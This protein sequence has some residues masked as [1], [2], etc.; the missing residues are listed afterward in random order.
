MALI[1]RVDTTMYALGGTRQF[2]VAVA[3]VAGCQSRPTPG[4]CKARADE[5]AQFIAALDRSPRMLADSTWPSLHLV[6]RAELAAPAPG[7]P[8]LAIVP[9]GYVSGGDSIETADELTLV[10]YKAAQVAKPPVLGLAIDRAVTWR[11]I[12]DTFEL[13]A[14][15]GFEQVEL[16]YAPPPV[17]PSAS[18]TLETSHCELLGQ[19]LDQRAAAAIPPALEACGCRA[20]AAAV[21]VSAWAVLAN[22]HPMRAVRLALDRAGT[23]HAHP[24]TATWNEIA[25]T[26][27]PGAGWLTTR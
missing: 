6:E 9:D 25:P 8:V 27:Q 12:V 21:E 4:E 5:V 16:Y 26:L 1:E 14:R 7:T 20:D 10:L 22:H 23:I 15:E 17:Q 24:A 3:L 19:A 13:A 18:T 11:R 2:L